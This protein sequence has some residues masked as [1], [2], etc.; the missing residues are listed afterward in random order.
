MKLRSLLAVAILIV[1][2]RASAGA[3]DTTPLKI[4]VLYAFTTAGSG[5]SSGPQVDAAIATYQ[6]E[7]GD[8][9]DGHKIVLIRRDT[10]GPNEEVVQR[11]AQELI[12]NDNVD[13]IMGLSFSPDAI[14]MG[15]ISTRA[16]KP[17]FIV[18]SAT[19]NVM[20]N[21]PYMARFA[22]TNGAVTYALARW[23]HSQG[24][25]KMFNF[26]SDYVTGA[27]A[28]KSFTKFYESDGISKVVGESK[29]PLLAKDF[30]PYLLHVRDS[31]AEAMF[32]FLGAGENNA[33][34]LREYHDLGL[35]KKGIKIVA[36]GSMVEDDVLDSE[37]DPAIGLVSA[38][39][40]SSALQNLANK[41]F[42]RDFAAASGHKFRANFAAY[43]TYDVL[44]AIYTIAKLQ[45]GRLDPDKT[46]Q[47]VRGM[48]FESPRGTITI[49]PQTRDIVQNIYIRRVEKHNGQLVNVVIG[50]IPTVKN[51]NETYT[52]P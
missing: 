29:P 20:A 24:Y 8:S 52:T 33:L 21:A 27:D 35:D 26:Y 18:N 3:A 25:H 34:F 19:D 14:T 36:I 40:Y 38:Y 51:P 11:L 4:G 5:S 39:H 6:K 45:G 31:D 32:I 49:D 43:G 10:T 23:A 22:Y 50:T 9:V 47:L 37:G 30:A 13:M 12:V 28:A 1:V 42:Q 41:R 2:G 7:H 17:V 16:K 15:P 48:S 46:M 44:N